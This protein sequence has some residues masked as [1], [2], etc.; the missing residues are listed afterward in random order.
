MMLSIFHL[1]LITEKEEKYDITG[2]EKSLGG[3]FDIC[4]AVREKG[5]C[6]ADRKEWVDKGCS[7]DRRGCGREGE[8][9][10]RSYRSRRQKN[11]N[12][13]HKRQERQNREKERSVCVPV[14]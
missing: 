1:A 14:K 10:G 12:G 6:R 9:E 4:S 8:R 5:I 13:K 2:E 7:G 3:R 11:A